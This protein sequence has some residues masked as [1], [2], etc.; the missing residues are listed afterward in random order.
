M[1][2]VVDNKK[3]CSK[4][5][6]NKDLSFYTGGQNCISGKSARCNDCLRD[7]HKEYYKN[8]KEKIV[9]YIKNWEK[10]NPQKRN[11]HVQLGKAI[12]AGVIIKP[13]TCSVC[14]N[15]GRIEGH[16]WRGYSEENVLDVQWLCVPCHKKIDM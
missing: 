4:C 15:T 16:H 7:Y 11:A 14:G 3:I 1:Y 2:R 12:S 8:N 13:D 9:G 6:E 10:N 5:G